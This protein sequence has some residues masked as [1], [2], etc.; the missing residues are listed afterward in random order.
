MLFVV[1]LASA[2]GKIKGDLTLR[3]EQ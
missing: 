3:V 2:Y 1:V